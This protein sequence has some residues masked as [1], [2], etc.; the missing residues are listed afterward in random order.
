MAE[1]AAAEFEPLRPARVANV[2]GKRE[3]KNDVIVVAGVEHDAVGRA[4]GDDALEHVERAVAI[5]RRDFNRND[6]V[7]SRERGPEINAEF[8]PTHRRL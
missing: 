2:E 3:V 8:A 5:E 6:V 7:E 4:C 1:Q